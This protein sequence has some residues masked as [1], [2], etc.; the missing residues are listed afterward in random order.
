M[1]L[2]EF[3]KNFHINNE[4]VGCNVSR[5]VD[6]NQGWCSSLELGAEFKSVGIIIMLHSIHKGHIYY[7]VYIKYQRRYFNI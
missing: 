1:I 2:F 4:T 5:Q 6:V 3:L 7:L